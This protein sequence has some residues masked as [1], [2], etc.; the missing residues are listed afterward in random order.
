MRCFRMIRGSPP[1]RRSWCSAAITDANARSPNGGTNPFVND[2]LDAFFNASVDAGIALSA[3]VIAAESQ[4]L[5]CCPIS[6]IRNHA[7]VV[8]ELLGLPDHVFPI[9]GMA[10]GW[11]AAE[12][13]ISMRLPLSVTVHRNQYSEVD[14]ESTVDSY[15]MLRRNAQPYGAQRYIEDFGSVE[16]YGW[17]EDK[18]RQ[19][20]RPERQDFG[21]FVR[22]KGF[23]LD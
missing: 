23:N 19:Y 22:K 14:I 15:D 7:Q 8:S 3:F 2:H 5:G 21:S 1:P 18:A 9:A 20:A 6:A 10:L 16:Y 13:R 17:S 11:P 4:G 12:P